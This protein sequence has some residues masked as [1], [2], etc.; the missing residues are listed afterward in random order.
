MIIRNY[1]KLI[2]AIFFDSKG[3]NCD[4]IL[5]CGDCSYYI[6]QRS[7]TYTQMARM[8]DGIKENSEQD[9]NEKAWIKFRH[10]A[11]C[12]LFLMPHDHVQTPTKISESDREK[13]D[14]Y[15]SGLRQRNV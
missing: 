11:R 10:I 7:E 1:W 9:P 14:N 13:M 12:L 5:T 8:F 15:N 3:A 2:P 6:I 4:E